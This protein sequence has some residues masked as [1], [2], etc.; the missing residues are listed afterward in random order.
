M[1]P[2][3]QIIGQP[4]EMQASQF[5]EGAVFIQ[6]QS[7]APTIIGVFMII[8]GVFTVFGGAWG[9]ITAKDTIALLDELNAELDIQIDIPAWFIWLKPV[10]QLVS[11]IA[12]IAGGYFLHQRKKIG[13]LIGWG[14]VAISAA[15]GVLESSIMTSVYESLEFSA[16]AGAAIG[17]GFTLFCNGICGFIIAIPLMSNT[18]NLE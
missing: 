4:A 15:L 9:L 7:S 18:S 2:Q 1:Q 17:M 5:P 13:V 16:A 6:K 11:G 10:V 12:F 8:T 14:G 3:P